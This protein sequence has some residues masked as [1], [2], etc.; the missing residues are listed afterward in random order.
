[1]KALQEQIVAPDELAGIF[2]RFTDTTRRLEESHRSLQARV[3]ELQR[4]LAEKNR[5]LERKKRL[6][7][8]GEMAAAVAHEIRN[9][10][11]GIRLCAGLLKREVTDENNGRL[12]EKI[13]SGVGNL[14][15]VI[16]GM[17]AFTRN[18]AP[19]ATRCN[20]V[21]VLRRAAASLESEIEDSGTSVSFT[22]PKD[23]IFIQADSILLV[24]AF[25][26]II[27]NAIQASD[28]GAHIEIRLAEY[29]CGAE[30]SF[31]DDGPGIGDEIIEK[32]F[33]PFFTDRGEGTGLGLAIVHRIVEAH[34]GGIAA[35]NLREG[36]ALFT[37]RLPFEGGKAAG[38]AVSD[39]RVAGGVPVGVQD[40][41]S[42]GRIE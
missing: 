19:N 2:R 24:R 41:E 18:L 9:P 4:E 11:G 1:M 15:G 6:A 29:S 37:V 23:D 27:Q 30:I 13:I 25:S 21:D 12:V 20:P 32:I 34:G 3:E 35:S 7:E 39:G 36:G 33:N 42:T 26:N 17:L 8:L 40:T 38:T 5:E 31:R 28:G 16:E 14:N 22:M 10:L